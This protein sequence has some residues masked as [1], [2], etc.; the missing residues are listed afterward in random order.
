LA[1]QAS[2]AFSALFTPSGNKFNQD[3]RGFSQRFKK[4]DFEEGEKFDIGSCLMNT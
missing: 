1:A 2:Q 3:I 4:E